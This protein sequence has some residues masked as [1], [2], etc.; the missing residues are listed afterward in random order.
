MYYAI[1]KYSVHMIVTCILY[2]HKLT[3]VLYYSQRHNKIH[4]QVSVFLLYIFH[5]LVQNEYY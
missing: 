3:G 1:V 5:I 4:G 2:L